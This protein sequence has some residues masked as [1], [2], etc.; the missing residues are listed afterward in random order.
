MMVLGGY[1]FSLQ[2]AAPQ[3]VKHQREWEWVENEVISQTPD[4]QYTGPKPEKMTL[5]GVMYPEYYGGTLQ[6]DTIAVM[7]SAGLPM[8]LV[9]GVG[10]ILGF[11]VI[12]S[13][14]EDKAELDSNGQPRK[15]EF[16][17]GLKQ[18]GN[19]TAAIQ[20]LVNAAENLIG[21]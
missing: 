1:L 3:G 20:S 17:I 5:K 13:V 15:I 4:L 10:M 2:T 18:F 21:V 9:S 8:L 7:A 19:M 6:M 16:E 14:I 11:W 12:E